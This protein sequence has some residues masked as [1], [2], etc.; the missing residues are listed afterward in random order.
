ML[1]SFS[2]PKWE[3]YNPRPD[4]PNLTWFRMDS[5]FFESQSVYGLTPSAITLLLFMRCRRNSAGT[6]R[7]ELLTEYLADRLK[8]D[9]REIVKNLQILNERSLIRLSGGGVLDTKEPPSATSGCP[10]RRDETVRDDTKNT[11]AA[12]SASPPAAEQQN[13]FKTVKVHGAMVGDETLTEFSEVRESL[14]GRVK[15]DVQ[16]KWL[17]LYS[18]E[19]VVR[20]V[21]ELDLWCLNNPERAPRSRWS[22]FYSKCLA[23]DWERHRTTLPRQQPVKQP[24][25]FA[26]M[27]A[28]RAPDQK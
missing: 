23:R 15:I 8:I 5:D 4:R 6:E 2:I 20:K 1:I 18:A 28:Q 17:E 12:A 25:A 24:S 21:K 19:F 16:K 11:S 27:E 3:Q 13:L 9:E 14:R 22:A 7:V 10:T 26:Q